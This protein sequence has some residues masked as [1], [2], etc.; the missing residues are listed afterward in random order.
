VKRDRKEQK[1]MGG[2]LVQKYKKVQREEVMK[3]GNEGEEELMG[4]GMRQC[5]RKGTLNAEGEE[6]GT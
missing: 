5:R 4:L 1:V 6:Y 3:E 2:K